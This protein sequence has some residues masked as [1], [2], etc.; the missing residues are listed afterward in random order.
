MIA[1]SPLRRRTVCRCALLA[2]LFAACRSATAPPGPL[3][4][5]TELA[6]PA[7]ATPAAAVATVADE[8]ITTFWC[9]PPLAAFDDAR[10][11]E[12]AAAGFTVV[13]APCE[14]EIN[15]QLNRRALDTAQRHGLRVLISDPRLHAARP[16]QEGWQVRADRA[17]ATYR[18]HPALAGFFVVDEPGSATVYADIAAL[19]RRIERGTPGAIAYVNLLPDYVFPGPDDY[20]EYVEG[21]LFQ[22]RPR[23][24]SY[25]YYPFL[26]EADRPSFL[27]NMTVIRDLAREYGVPFMLIVQLMPHAEY[28]DITWPELT[29]QVYHALV[30]GARGISYFA[31]WTPTQVPDNLAYRFRKGI[32]EGGRATEHYEMVTRL[33]HEVRAIATALG[34]YSHIS[35]SDWFTAEDSPAA[36]PAEISVTS[37]SVLFGTFEN[38]QGQRAY[39]VVNR[40][41]HRSARLSLAGTAATARVFSP[42][43]QSWLLAPAQFDLPAGEGRLFAFRGEA[44]GSQEDTRAAPRN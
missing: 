22:T 16:L 6:S 44:G 40:D 1:R 32:I 14:G 2:V 36:T 12:I 19:R 26:T 5:A 27:H 31:Y 37:G 30:F 39:L 13:G 43:V 15:P 25:D 29:W 18:G 10:A 42:S 9:G 17:I 21:Y 7:P 24:L 3:P 11:A 38:P 8:F 41:Y 20:R 34:G 35:T 33:N 28:R 23:L 4:A